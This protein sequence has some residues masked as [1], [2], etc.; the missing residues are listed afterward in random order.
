MITHQGRGVLHI[1]F[2]RKGEKRTMSYPVSEF[3]PI[4]IGFLSLSI[5]YFV[6]GGEALFGGPKHSESNEAT[7]KALGL[8]GMGLGGFGQL[9]TGIYLMVGLSWFPV[10]REAAPLYM[11]AVA[12][13]VYGIH[14]I[15]MGYRRYRGGD[16]GPDAWMAIPVLGLG[17]LGMISFL[18]AGD[19]PA[20]ILFIGL[21]LIYIFEIYYRFTNSAFGGKAVAFFQLLT[22]IWLLYLTFGVTLNLANGMHWWI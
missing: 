6:Q 12:F 11:A 1:R 16:P 15:V 21:S 20:G 3:V 4:G 9:I 22:G 14:W 7:E 13:T 18:K 10:Y 19:V 8:W 2:N 5:N 17:V